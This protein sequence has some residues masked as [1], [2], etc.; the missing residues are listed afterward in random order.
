MFYVLWKTFSLWTQKRSIYVP[1]NYY[2]SYQLL[3]ND[4]N[5]IEKVGRPTK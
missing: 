4:E 1:I 5:K 3:L 2:F